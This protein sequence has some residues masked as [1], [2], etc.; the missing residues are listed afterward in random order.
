MRSSDLTETVAIRECHNCGGGSPAFDN[1][2]R[3]CGVRQETVTPTAAD[4]AA[5]PEGETN[6]ART[7]GEEYQTLSSQLVN[8]LTQTISVKTT[9]IRHNRFWSSMVAAI[10]SV[11]ILLLIILLSPLDAYAAARAAASQLNYR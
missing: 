9:P 8:T 10:I 5:L 6:E 4:I 2:C 11:P 3:W 7:D 1:Y